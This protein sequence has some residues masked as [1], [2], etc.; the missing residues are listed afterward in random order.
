MTLL[1]VI[2]ITGGVGCGKSAVL[3]FLSEYCSCRI[4]RADEAAEELTAPGGACYEAMCRLLEAAE[5]SGD[6]PLFPEGHGKPFDR[7]EAAGRMYRSPELRGRIDALIHPAVI[8]RIMESIEEER[9]EGRS[10]FFFLEAALLIETGFL[11]IVDEMWYIY[12][13]EELRRHRLR[14]SR[15]YSDERIDAMIASQLSEREFRENADFVV[16][17]GGSY[18]EARRQAAG[19]VDILRETGRKRAEKG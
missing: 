10:E 3:D 13:P 2:G 11:K 6:G 5:K 14:Q 18:E 19:R 8:R 16:D 9:A 7:R 12:C 4:L 17:N 15:G 1:Y